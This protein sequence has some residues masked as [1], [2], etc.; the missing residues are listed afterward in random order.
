MN[1]L[2]RYLLGTTGALMM[3][4]NA[5]CFFI[6]D[7][8]DEGDLSLN[9]VLLIPDAV[10]G[11]PAAALTCADA[12]LE[13]VG[14]ANETLFVRLSIGDDLNGDDFLD[15]GETFQ[16]VA[17]SCNQFDANGDVAIDAGELGFL[18]GTYDAG[19]FSHFAVSLED[20][21][22]FGIPFELAQGAG[23]FDR[24]AFGGGI[25]V[26]ENDNFDI[27]FLDNNNN[28]QGLIGELQL[29]INF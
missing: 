6:I 13:A 26:F 5:G 7:D 3:A 24:F 17:Q 22:G 11:L 16:S 4:A 10:T 25:E 1:T 14:D 20:S 8:N 2:T 29:F 28:P 18:V 12:A 21:A 23:A 27:I 15:E 19:A 9:Y